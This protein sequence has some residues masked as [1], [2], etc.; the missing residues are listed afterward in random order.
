MGH[1]PAGWGSCTVHLQ[2]AVEDVYGVLERVQRGQALH[3]SG[4]WLQA[5]T[6]AL[7]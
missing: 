5:L 3:H 2:Q 6:C 7:V 4:T 1:R